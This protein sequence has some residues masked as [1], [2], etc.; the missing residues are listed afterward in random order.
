M[1]LIF[2]MKWNGSAI[3][4][5]YTNMEKLF[6]RED[7]RTMQEV[8][9]DG[10]KN[11]DGLGK[12]PLLIISQHKE[13]GDYL[14]LLISNHLI[15]SDENNKQEWGLSLHENYFTNLAIARSLSLAIK[16]SKTQDTAAYLQLL[17]E[18]GFDTNRL[19][20]LSIPMTLFSKLNI[21]QSLGNAQYIFVYNEV[22]ETDDDLTENFPAMEELISQQ[23]EHCFVLNAKFLISDPKNVIA[24]LAQFTKS[25]LKNPGRI[26][27]HTT[28]S[29]D[30]IEA[31]G[32]RAEHIESWFKKFD[33]MAAGNTQPKGKE[34]QVIFSS[35]SIRKSNIVFSRLQEIS[36]CFLYS[37]QF[38][39]I[40]E[41]AD[42]RAYYKK[43]LSSQSVLHPDIVFE[44]KKDSLAEQL[45]TVIG[46]SNAE[47]T[48]ID[49]LQT[50]YS[51]LNFFQGEH[52]EPEHILSFSRVTSSLHVYEANISDLL[53][54][55]FA[56]HT[57]F[58]SKKDWKELNGFDTETATEYMLWEYAIR[59]LDLYKNKAF[60]IPSVFSATSPP[61]PTQEFS[62]KE[63][64][65]YR[66][67][68]IKHRQ[69]LEHSLN[70]V[71]DLASRET[72]HSQQ[73]KKVLF[74]KIASLQLI[75]TH[76]KDELKSLQQLT[77][78]LH[79]RIH[80]LENNWYQKVRMKLGR[81]KK[82][83]F[84]KKSPGTGSLKRLLLFIRFSFSKAGFGI[85]RKIL[86]AVFKKLFLLI[87]KRPVKII[88]TDMIGSR[89]IFTYND[90]VLKK[91]DS[92]DILHDYEDHESEMT[93]KPLIS[94]IM[95]V[96]N[97][98]IRF[99]KEAIES[100]SN[101]VYP[102]WELCIADDHSTEKRVHKLLH[103]FSVKDKRIQIHY[104][105]EN[106]HISA[107]SN[108]ALAMA[109]GEFV[110]LM[111]HD[112]LLSANCLWEMVKAINAIP[113][114]DILYSDEDKIDERKYHQ[115]AHFKPDWAPDHLLSRNYLGHVTVLKRSLINMIGGFRLGLEGSQDYDLMLRATEQTS[116]I[117][118]IPKVLY[119]WRIHQHSAAQGEDVKPYAYVAAKKALE[120]ALTRRGLQGDV[121]YLSGLRGYR[122]D[123]QISSQ[124]LISI[125]IPTKDQTA[126]LKNT[127]DSIIELTRYKNYEIIVLN[128]N[129]TSKE[130]YNWVAEYKQKYPAL[131]QIVDAHFPFN[132]SKLMNLGNSLA[133]GKHLLLLNNDVEIIHGDWLETMLSYSQQQRIGAV[134]VRLLYPDDTIQ[135]AGVVV[136]LG[137]IAGHTFVGSYKDE[138]GYF[139]YIQSVNN[140]SAVTA[141]CLMCRKEV[142]ESVGGMDE[143]F[144][145]EYNDVDFCLKIMEAGYNNVY[146]PQVE[147]YHYES[148]TRGH[149][150]QSKSSY[151]RHLREMKLFK[152]KWQH[153]IDHDPF[154]NPNLNL[155]AHDFSIN[156]SS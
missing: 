115:N 82:I 53:I 140:Y 8:Q 120:E 16:T 148:A 105:T 50:K 124:D 154:Y 9:G 4:G 56:E 153:I 60:V 118:H 114:A 12:T 141:A 31:S 65:D 149:P 22:E 90:W 155:G 133:K 130:F 54:K 156:F 7:K 80:Y 26:L 99:L 108:D 29:D 92:D 62:K 67:V 76:A 107:T 134:G 128:N 113:K 103:V 73:E 47:F 142:F 52:T 109:K 151:E 27:P 136:G 93:H 97:A 117:I 125:I 58:F 20:G 138:A 51:F 70:E 48:C 68:L 78:Q 150:H 89:D 110:L 35:V 37:P 85:V 43:K 5:S 40:C 72:Y 143:T 46:E 146:L 137:G 81:I 38:T 36:C 66:K 147:L 18:E 95:P 119:H 14:S 21:S 49:D 28:F 74:E 39:L 83:F 145:V 15:P 61:S 132:F 91:L 122:I 121:K 112:D 13:D 10:L 32:K 101:Q 131:I 106:G 64:Q 104:R 86:A 96:Y 11:E 87:E 127:I 41:D 24:R 77:S 100:V 17:M 135:H 129:S 42:S 98:P 116:N 79:Q 1:S 45:N 33:S 44:L 75:S 19:F 94:I 111:D 55:D 57:L 3:M 71:I 123:Y 30:A 152:S 69:L 139:N 59:S 84:K 63:E 23:P 88:Y 34:I 2:L 102:N 6:N 25:T 144:E 126:L